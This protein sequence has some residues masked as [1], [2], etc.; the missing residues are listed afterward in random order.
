MTGPSAASA[1]GTRV[2]LPVPGAAVTTAALFSRTRPTISWIQGSIGRG[3]GTSAIMARL[4]SPSSDTVSAHE[5]D[6]V[7]S[8]ETYD[9]QHYKA[10]MIAW[11][12]KTLDVK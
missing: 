9:Q 11:P 4:A 7:T 5:P 1:G 8:R 2:V 6:T 12:K 3:W 10:G